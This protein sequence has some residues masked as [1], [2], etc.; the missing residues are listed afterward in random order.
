MD[1]SLVNDMRGFQVSVHPSLEDFELLA[2]VSQMLT[3]LDGERVLERV[4][5]LMIRRSARNTAACSS[6]PNTATTGRASSPS[7]FRPLAHWNRRNRRRGWRSVSSTRVWWV[8]SSGTVKARSSKRP[9]PFALGC[10]AGNNPS[11]GSALCVPFMWNGDVLAALTL[12]HSDTFHFSEYHLRLFT[13]VVNQA[14]GAVR[15][16]QLFAHLLEQRQQMEAI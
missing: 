16:A 13:I 3:Q 12:T 5:D 1:V 2:E 7:T 10:L 4:I 15:N 8:G 14:T 9:P 11:S 6:I